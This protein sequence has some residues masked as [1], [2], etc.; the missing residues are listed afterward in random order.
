MWCHG[1]FS[2]PFAA[3]GKGARPAERALSRVGRAGEP[4][5]DRRRLWQL[6]P[7]LDSTVV[8]PVPGS[9]GLAGPAV[10][11]DDFALDPV[12]LDG[13]ALPPASVLLGG[14]QRRTLC[15]VQRP[16]SP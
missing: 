14:S 12:Q 8:L 5:E 2:T 7:A 4:G 16:Q 3:S 13:T 9:R 15:R 1:D 11:I 6:D 10:V